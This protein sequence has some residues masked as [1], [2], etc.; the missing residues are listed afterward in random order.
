MK[1][2]ERAKNNPFF[3]KHV[4]LCHNMNDF[5]KVSEPKVGH[6]SC[7]IIHKIKIIICSMTKKYKFIC[8]TCLYTYMY[9]N[10][11]TAILFVLKSQ[12]G[13]KYY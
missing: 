10:S 5:N 8:N 12:L 4:K 2:F 3:F 7:N 11:C 6:I 1:S 9:Y 13:I